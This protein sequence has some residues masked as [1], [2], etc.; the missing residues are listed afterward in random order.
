MD[1][2]MLAITSALGNLG[3]SAINDAYQALKVA[4]QKKYGVESDLVEA[5]N[6]LEKK[7]DSDGRLGMLQEEIKATEAS[8]D[9][10]ILKFAQS[11]LEVV[12]SQ[13]GGDGKIQQIINQSV[14]GDRNI[15]S[16]SGD[17]TVKRD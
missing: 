9:D 4:L 17:V 12:K 6:K 16:G 1:P 15:F 2:I 3:V 8:K 10:E 13:P 11:L 14:K 5:V 7:P